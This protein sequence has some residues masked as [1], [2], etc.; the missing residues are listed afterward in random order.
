MASVFGNLRYED[1][2]LLDPKE[3]HSYMGNHP[4]SVGFTVLGSRD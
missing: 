3:L 4:I 1:F 2:G